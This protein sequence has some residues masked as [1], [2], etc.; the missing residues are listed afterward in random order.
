[1]EVF[2]GTKINTSHLAST[3]RAKVK[4]RESIKKKE[5]KREEDQKKP[6]EKHCINQGPNL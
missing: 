3:W 5:A 1:M 2:D 6:Q 4:A